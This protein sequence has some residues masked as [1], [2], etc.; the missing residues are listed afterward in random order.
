M[1][2]L[3]EVFKNHKAF[4]PFVTAG[5]P[6]AARTVASVVA[7]AEA[8]ADIVEL[9]VPFSDPIADGPVI[10]AAG[11][12]AFAGG[13]TVNG[14]FDI[15]AEI[16]KQTQVPLVFL[17]YANLPF[18]Y[19]YDAFCRRCAALGVA[20][21]VIPDLPAEEAG[22][23]LP[24]TKKHG[25]DLIPLVSP[26]SGSR[27]A[28]LVTDATGFIYIVSALGVTGQRAGFAQNLPD[29]IAALRQVTDAPLCVGFGVHTPEQAR[30]LAGLADGVIVGSAIVAQAAAAGD[31]APAAIAA[32]TRDMVAAVRQAE[33]DA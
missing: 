16:R 8:G 22:E 31:D 23:I 7:L 10:Q 15:V 18:K 33:V 2:K 30:E 25:L 5:D 27:L 9:G 17:T 28:K 6:S 14:V 29:L 21:L 1:S 11:L 3:R 4:I 13:I 32:Y 19:G 24:F 26:T 20:G 12:R